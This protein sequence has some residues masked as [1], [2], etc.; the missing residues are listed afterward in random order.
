MNKKDTILVVD[1]TQVN[2]D[3]LVGLLKD[4]DIVVAMNGESALEVANNETNIDLILLDIMMPDM[5]GFEVCEKLKLN[6]KTK[7]IPI[8]FITAKTDDDSIQKAFELGGVDYITKPFR[9]IEL[10]QRIK[11]HLNLVAHEKKAIDE[12]KFI[13]LTELIRNISHQWRQP[14]SVISTAASGMSMQKEIGVLKDKEFYEFCEQIISNTQYLSTTI[15]SFHNLIKN[16]STKSTFNIKALVDNN[17]STLFDKLINENISIKENI[18]DDVDI[19]G[20]PIE[21]IQLLLYL[22]DN[23]KDVLEVSN[24]NGNLMF[25]NI[26]KDNQTAYIEIVDNG[27]GISEDIIEKVFEP[28]FTTYHQ[29]QGKGL[30]L[31][32]SRKIIIDSFY[33]QIDVSNLEFEYNNKKQKGVKF[34]IQIP[35]K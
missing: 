12:S 11:T 1:D 20:L 34:D 35:I 13:A 3:I 17:Y 2:I 15:D 6:S 4:Y 21:F 22:I 31:Y 32:L 24:K 16:Q 26:K 14:L 23:V 8:I 7:N 27:G 29:S 19:Y 10:R 18:Q 30:G 33:G 28:Y 25:L 5:N 9:S